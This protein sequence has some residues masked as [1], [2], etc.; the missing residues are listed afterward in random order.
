MLLAK[1][2]IRKACLAE[3]SQGGSEVECAV[4]TRS[5]VAAAVSAPNLALRNLCNSGFTVLGSAP[6]SGAG[7]SESLRE[8]R[9]FCRDRRTRRAGELPASTRRA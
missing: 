5:A 8:S 7:D 3:A 6:L 9:T 4:T 2:D 1:L